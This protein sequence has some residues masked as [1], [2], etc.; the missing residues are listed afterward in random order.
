MMRRN[1]QERSGCVRFLYILVGAFVVFV[2]MANIYHRWVMDQTQD[3]MNTLEEA[4][5][6]EFIVYDGSL[7]NL[8]KLHEHIE[9]NDYSSRVSSIEQGST[10]LWGDQ[11]Q[12]TLNVWYEDI[13]NNQVSSS[14]FVWY[15][16][17]KK[18][19][20][21]WEMEKIRVMP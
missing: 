6:D 9:G 7:S 8:N 11:G 1:R 2:I 20:G 18:I 12:I 21:V 16:D 13:Q 15:I 10:W 4:V 14:R 17:L 5:G 3:I 19:D